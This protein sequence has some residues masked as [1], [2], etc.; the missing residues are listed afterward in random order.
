MKGSSSKHSSNTHPFKLHL[1]LIPFYCMQHLQL[2]ISTY[3][4][5]AVQNQRFDQLF[6]FSGLRRSTQGDESQKQQD[7]SS[8]G[9]RQQAAREQQC[10]GFC[11]VET[12]QRNWGKS[13]VT[14]GWPTVSHSLSHTP[15]T[16]PFVQVTPL[17][18]HLADTH[19]THT[20]TQDS[21]TT[22][23]QGNQ[24]SGVHKMFVTNVTIC[25]ICSH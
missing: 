11:Q 1:S 8:H 5:V 4:T 7:Q 24:T 10:Q 9:C 20:H 21:N 25:Y 14:V 12:L 3:R 2:I 13:C 6:A 22:C 16:W 19:V 15:L 17:H 18:N 23:S